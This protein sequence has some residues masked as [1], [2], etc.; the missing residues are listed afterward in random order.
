M[1]ERTKS[2]LLIDDDDFVAGSLHHYLSAEGYAADVALDTGYGEALMRVNDYDVVVVDPY[3]TA[4]IRHNEH[5]V[6]DTIRTLQPQAA[7]IVLTAYASEPLLRLAGEG[8]VTAVVAKPQP[9]LRLA[10]LVKDSMS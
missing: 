9:L 7:V 2:I 8:R 6:I 3:L 10:H 4:R 5:G 1:F